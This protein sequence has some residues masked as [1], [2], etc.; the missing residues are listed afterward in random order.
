MSRFWYS[1][2]LV[3]GPDVEIWGE[4]RPKHHSNVQ[5]CDCLF[6]TFFFFL[7]WDLYFLSAGVSEI[8]L[9]PLAFL[10]RFGESI[11]SIFPGHP[12]GE[13]L[14]I[15]GYGRPLFSARFLRFKLPRA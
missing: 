6:E 13:I 4:T 7:R 1:E 9:Y 12:M 11:L 10:E 5:I 3:S 15:R 2:G 8:Y 14:Y